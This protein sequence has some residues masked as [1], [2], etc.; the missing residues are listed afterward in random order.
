[1]NT[2]IAFL[3]GINVSGQKKIK[4]A[5]LRSCLEHSGLENLRT[6]IQ[7]GN[8]VFD[9]QEKDSSVIGTKIFEVIKTN[10]GYEVPILVVEPSTLQQVLDNN[11]FSSIAE[12]K[13]QYFTLLFD[14]PIVEMKESFQQ[15]TFDHEDFHYSDKCIYLNC[16][17]GAGKAKLNNNL[18]EN[19]LKIRA[20]TRNLNTMQKMV[21]LANGQS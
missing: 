16:K 10:F 14:I 4:M 17:L 5:D 21:Q 2:F 3:R 1:M 18:I 20:T 15:M 9:T 19:K 11:P 6:Y 8:L 7:S 13:N 12:Q